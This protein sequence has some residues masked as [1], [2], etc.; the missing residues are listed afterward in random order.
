MK[1][2]INNTDGNGKDFVSPEDLGRCG[3]FVHGDG[4]VVDGGIG[5]VN[6]VGTVGWCVTK[7]AAGFAA[8]VGILTATSPE[9]HVDSKIG[10]VEALKNAVGDLL[11]FSANVKEHA[12]LSAAAT[13]ERG[14]EV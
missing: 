6:K 13:L 3:I 4:E 8:R 12:T 7:T 11:E 1:K 9:Y 14:V 2:G 5:T 10:I